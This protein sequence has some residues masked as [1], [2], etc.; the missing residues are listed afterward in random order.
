MTDSNKQIGKSNSYEL[1]WHTPNKVLLL[2]LT[3]DY[4]VSEA[5]EVNRL[6]VG[7][8][9]HAKDGLLILIDATNM[10]RPFN[11]DLI[12]KTQTYMV[13]WNLKQ[14]H[15]VAEDRIIKLAMMVIFNLSSVSPILHNTVDSAN[16]MIS[17]QLTSNE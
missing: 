9:D 2:T 8:L 3:G 12:R 17:R 11:F 10:A 7:Q 14:L 13:H 15:V 4:E 6:V 5:K 16:Q 1:V